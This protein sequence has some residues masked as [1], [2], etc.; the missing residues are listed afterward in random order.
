MF[1]LSFWFKVWTHILF[2]ALYWNVKNDN[3]RITTISKKKMLGKR[4]LEHDA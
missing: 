3:R 1:C 2:C 4:R